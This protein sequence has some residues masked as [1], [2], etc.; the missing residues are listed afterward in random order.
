MTF[1]NN[2]DDSPNNHETKNAFQRT[3]AIFELSPD[4][5]RTNVLTK[6]HD[7]GTYKSPPLAAMF[8]QQTGTI[9]ELIYDVIITNV[10][11]KCLEECENIIRTNVLT[12]FY[13]DLKIM[14]LLEC[15]Q[16]FYNSH[17]R[18]N[19]PTSC[20]NVFQPTE[21]NFQLLQNIIGSNLLTKFHEDRTKYGLYSVNKANVVDE[22][23][24]THDVQKA[25]P[26]AHHEHALV[27]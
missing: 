20:C 19:A 2:A 1:R 5:I 25:I 16:C 27:S 13:E 3:K 24:T 4:I 15:E 12:K 6:F 18:L 23:R 9:F 21:H 14:R 7:D 22:G 17:I 26:T 8:F 11:T 10:F